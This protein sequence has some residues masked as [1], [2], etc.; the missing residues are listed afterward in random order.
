MFDLQAQLILH[1]PYGLATCQSVSRDNGSGV[2]FRFYELIGTAQQLGSDDHDRSRA[3]TDFFVLLLCKIDKDT[4]SR[5]FYR[6]ER[7]DSRAVI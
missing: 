1:E 2:N 4:A 3:I 6:E 7:K 5:M